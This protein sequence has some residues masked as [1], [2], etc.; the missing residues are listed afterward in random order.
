MGYAT[1]LALASDG[2][3]LYGIDAVSPSDQAIY[4]IDPAT[5]TATAV[6]SLSGL[7]DG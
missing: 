3:I 6:G 7:V 1:T 2:N 5:G 4:T